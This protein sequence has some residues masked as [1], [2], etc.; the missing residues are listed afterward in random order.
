MGR[1]AAAVVV[2]LATACA[3]RMPVAAPHVVAP[4]A[5]AAAPIVVDAKASA[6]EVPEDED[7]VTPCREGSPEHEAAADAL[8][9]LGRDIDALPLTGD[10]A[11]I[12]ERLANLVETPCF[13]GVGTAG[14]LA[15]ASFGSALSLKTYWREG[16]Q[17]ALEAR[18]EWG[19]ASEHRYYWL[20]PSIRTALTMENAPKTHPL[21]PLLCSGAST[22]C[23]SETAGW[24]MRAA[25]AFRAHARSESAPSKDHASCK[26]ATTFVAF[27]ECVQ[28]TSVPEDA[29]PLGTF[30]APASGWLVLRGR[31]GHYQ[32]CNELRA[33]D[34]ATGSAYIASLCG[35]MTN[36]PLQIKVERGKLPLD[37]LREAAW[38]MFLAGMVDRHV[39]VSG[40]GRAIPPDLAIRIPKDQAFGIGIGGFGWSSG[41]TTLVYQWIRQGKSTATGTVTWPDAYDAADEH[42]TNL[43]AIAEAAFV[44]TCAGIAKLPAIPWS[45]RADKTTR[46]GNADAYYPE[47]ADPEFDDL[48]VE[49]MREAR[50][51]CTP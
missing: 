43:L 7:Y 32:W 22:S 3:P 2:L 4:A 33:Y 41:R 24:S 21:A 42:A 26:E 44:K 13:V 16:G 11:P 20:G 19:G 29:L 38:M 23:G 34:L 39:I 8:S 17:A 45:A 15:G 31:R 5:V 51:A 36:A 37:A 28:N 50:S 27:G 10:A 49:L 6:E 46:V 12:G 9:K 25:S 14:D 40:E 18:L 35:G 30:R 47:Y 1:R 48:E